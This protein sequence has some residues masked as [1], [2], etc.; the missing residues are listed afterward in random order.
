MT[1][2]KNIAALVGPTA[3][4]MGVSEMLNSHIW[5]AVTPP[6]TFQAGTMLF[7]AG[8]AIVRAH[9]SWRPDWTV[10]VTLVGWLALGLGALRIFFPELSQ[11]TVENSSIPLISQLL[12]LA[13]GLFLSFKAYVP[14]R[15]RAQ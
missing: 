7:V 4:A 2:S 13:V 11:R 5:A 12:V 14:E 6:I 15:G 10:V 3:V 1:N 8:L 9:N